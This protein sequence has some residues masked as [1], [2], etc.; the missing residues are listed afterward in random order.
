MKALI[1]E[2]EPVALRNLKR[3]LA[4]HFPD[5]EVAGSTSSVRETLDYLAQNSCDVIFM[6]VELQDGSCFDIFRNTAVN[7][8]VVMTTAYDSY[9][10]KAFEVNS[11]DYILKPVELPAL[12][13]ALERCRHASEKTDVSRLLDALSHGPAQGRHE[14]KERFLVRLNDRIVPV[15]ISD[16]AC[17]YSE[18]KA[19]YLMMKDGSRYV[20]N[21][22]LDDVEAGIDPSRFFRI[23]RSFIIA[24]ECVKSVVKLGGGRLRIICSP[25]AHPDAEVSRARVDD[26]LLWLEK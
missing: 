16:A 18:H 3:I 10:L 22:S 5:V 11:I 6:D 12:Q 19:T 8:H 15:N 9:A 24:K 13:R 23:S 17:F 25:A 7:A 26:F 21:P 20:L 2:D 1:V 14:Y 4:E